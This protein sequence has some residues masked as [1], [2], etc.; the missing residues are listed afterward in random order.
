MEIHA[1]FKDQYHEDCHFEVAIEIEDFGAWKQHL[2]L[3]GPSG[4]SS[5]EFT[6]EDE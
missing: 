6:K 1:E 5:E 3:R 2:W 4:V